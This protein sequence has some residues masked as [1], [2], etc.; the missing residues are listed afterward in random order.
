[1]NR[2]VENMSGNSGM[3]QIRGGVSE[4]FR[5]DYSNHTH[6][7]INCMGNSQINRKKSN[8]NICRK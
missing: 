1:M 6:S 5:L 4:T 8:L 7:S 2:S 3:N